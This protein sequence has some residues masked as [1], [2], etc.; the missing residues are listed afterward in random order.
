VV[1]ITPEVNR[2]SAKQKNPPGWG[3]RW[4]KKGG[5]VLGGGVTVPGKDEVVMNEL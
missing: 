4:G 5:F 2:L 1:Q 3:A